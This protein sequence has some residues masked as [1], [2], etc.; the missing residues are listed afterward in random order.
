MPQF[1]MCKKDFCTRKQEC[2]RYCAV[3]DKDQLYNAFPIICSL[4]DDYSLFIKIKENNR[5]VKNEGEVND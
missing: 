1:V 5:V 2:Y 4:D 3:P